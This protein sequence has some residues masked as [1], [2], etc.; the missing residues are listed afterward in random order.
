[1]L[2]KAEKVEV[3]RDSSEA[4]RFRWWSALLE[5]C[6]LRSSKDGLE[7]MDSACDEKE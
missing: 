5:S 2:S 6:G 7:V 4:E 1:M 3:M